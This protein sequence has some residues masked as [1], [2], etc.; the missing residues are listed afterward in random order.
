MVSVM[1]PPGN[2]KTAVQIEDVLARLQSGIADLTSSEAWIAWL[3]AARKF[4]RYSFS[5]QLLIAV[6]CPDATQVA[7][8]RTW[9]A[10]ERQVRKGEKGITIIAPCVRKGRGMSADGDTPDELDVCVTGFT[11]THVFD[12]AQTDGDPL[13]EICSQLF[14]DDPTDA[15]HALTAVANT[16]GFT[17]VVVALG[18]TLNGDCNHERRSIRIN[19]SVSPVQ[20]VKTLSHEIAHALLHEPADMPADVSRELR[21]LEAES[22]AYMVCSELGV[23]S[24]EYS[25]GYVAGWV[26]GGEAVSKAI[27][28]SA[29]RILQTVRGIVD[30]LE[31]MAV[32]TG[33]QG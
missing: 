29:Q 20:G 7:G 12:I 16:L 32:S 10:L 13:P 19:A 25:F 11:C 6:Q 9:Q 26:G 22:V 31:P 21:E 3:R 28:A 2:P 15:F 18:E 27:S 8:Y 23:D 17:V 33:S 14:G 30:A 1:D 4:H 24:G 5:N